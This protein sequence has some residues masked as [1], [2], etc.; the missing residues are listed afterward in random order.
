MRTQKLNQFLNDVTIAKLKKGLKNPAE[1]FK[2]DKNH[3]KDQ[4]MFGIT[5]KN[6]GNGNLKKQKT[7][8]KRR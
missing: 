5:T 8:P 7:K 1:F 2:M 6:S 3:G 4:E